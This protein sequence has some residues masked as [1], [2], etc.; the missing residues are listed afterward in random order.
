M[1]IIGRLLGRKKIK[2]IKEA[3]IVFK[4]TFNDF[5]INHPIMK[6]I[7]IYVRGELI[8]EIAYSD[9]E[10]DELKKEGV[11]IMDTTT[12]PNQYIPTVGIELGKIDL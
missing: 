10:I 8:D 4:D 9:V 7:R 12:E 3:K 11:P 2:F 1:N 6:E 5:P